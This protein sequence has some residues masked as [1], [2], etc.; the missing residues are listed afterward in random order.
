M[1]SEQF[2]LVTVGGGIGASALALAMAREGARVLVIEKEQKFRDRVRGEYLAPWGV[3]EAKELGIADLLMRHC[4]K[5]VPWVEMGFGPRNVAETTPQKMSAISFCHPEMQEVLL[6]EAAQA[7]VQVR[8]ATSVQG[9][10]PDANH[11]V[12]VSQN[13]KDERIE[14]RLV[15]GA[16][17]R[18]SAVRKWINFTTQKNGQH[19][20][21]AGVLLTGVAGRDDLVKFLFNPDLGLV[22]ATVP[23]T[24]QRWR[25]YLGYPVNSGLALQGSEKLKMFL[26]ESGKV[27]PGVQESYANV[28]SAGPLA[29]FEAGESWVDHPYRDGVALIGDAA[30]TN[31]PTFGQGMPMTLRDARVLRDALRSHSD[32]DS[33]GH[34]YARQHDEYFQNSRKVCG[35]LRTLFQDPSPPAQA[36]RGRAMPKIAED[37]SRVPDHLFGGPE[38]ACDETVR[39]RLFGEL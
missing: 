21:F 31:D 7:G 16:D 39:A 8:R 10:E 3:A 33:A 32:W 36:L 15:V 13:G 38:L 23:Q 9:I 24:R 25:A 4:A 6:A 30:G 18:G 12:V 28:E 2:D 34:E 11:P 35:W 14:A 27:A 17:G 37:Q 22:I 5:E 20:Q 19:F 29:S 1:K 26:A